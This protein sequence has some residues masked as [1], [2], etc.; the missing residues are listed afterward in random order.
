MPSSSLVSSIWHPSLD[1]HAP[2][3]VSMCGRLSR[4]EA[5]KEGGA[6][7]CHAEQTP[8]PACP[9]RPRTPPEWS[10]STPLAR[11]RGTSSMQWSTR[12]RLYRA[13]HDTYSLTASSSRAPSRSM[14]CLC[15]SSRMLSP[16]A[17]R[18][19]TSDPSLRTYVTEILRA[20]DT[21]ASTPVRAR[22]EHPDRHWLPTFPRPRLRHST[23]R[24][25]T[26]THITRM[27]ARSGGR[28]WSR[29]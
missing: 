17:P 7:T 6:R 22:A 1:L 10:Q 15:A 28:T 18:T 3:R 20:L 26:R 13:C 8:C 27:S 21:S 23:P 25:S 4:T 12:T 19:G 11:K 14:A 2:Q 16:M 29:V 5:V 9:P 24:R